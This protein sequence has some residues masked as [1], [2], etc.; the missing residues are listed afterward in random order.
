MNECVVCG[1]EVNVRSAGWYRQVTGW[2][3][4]RGG[5]GANK[6]ALRETTGQLMHLACM[7][8]KRMAPGQGAMFS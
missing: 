2:E 3:Q 1:D 6:I 7:D 8:K 5:G 4:V